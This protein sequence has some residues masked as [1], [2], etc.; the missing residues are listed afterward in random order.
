MPQPPARDVVDALLPWFR[1]HAR[2]LPWRRTRDPWAI[3]LS[4]VMLQQTRVET[5]K[6]YHR[7]FLAAWPTVEAFAAAEEQDVLRAWSGLGYYSRARNLHRAARAAVAAGGLPRTAAGW[8]ELP[9]VGP[10]TAGAVASIAFGERAPV[11]DGNVERVMCRVDLRRED[12]RRAGRAPLWAR[13][14]ELHEALRPDEAPGDLNQA[15]MEL[16]ATVCVPRSPR[17][18]ACPLVAVCAGR[19][20]A[21]SLPAKAPKKAPTEVVLAAAIL[22]SPAGT[23][24]V[25]RPDHGLFAGLWEPPMAP[26]APIPDVAPLV[27]VLTHRRLRVYPRPEVR[28]D[29][30]P[31][32]VADGYVAGRWVADPEEVPLS[33]LARKLLA[34]P[35]RPPG[36]RRPPR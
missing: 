3:W 7:N 28:A 20:E 19:G 36:R 34:V 31:L 9:G 22:T 25:R 8:R 26:T 18:V 21:S 11:V 32:A 33:I 1:R 24:L 23:W 15:L 10:Y 35:G 12:P 2:D 16:G 29:D 6:S 27:H 5:V 4:E 13:V 30:A 17:C 14:T